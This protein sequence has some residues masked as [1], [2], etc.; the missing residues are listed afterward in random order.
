MSG[1]VRGKMN[2]EDRAKQ[3]MPFAALKG[4]EMALR[5]KEHIVIPKQELSEERL[6]ELDETLIQSK[7][8]DMI[9]CIYYKKQEECYLK[10]TGILT[11]IDEEARLLKI[12]NTAISFDDIYELK[13]A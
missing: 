8:G 12:V 11:K 7:I 13:K 1:K 3:F 9:E 10:V 2:R 6:N 5:A 4:Y